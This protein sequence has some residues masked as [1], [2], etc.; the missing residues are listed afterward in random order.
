MR[1]KIYYFRNI[2][3]PL[4]LISLLLLFTMPLVVTPVDAG[5]NK[6]SNNTANT[7]YRLVFVL[8]TAENL[9]AL[10][11][12]AMDATLNAT[13]KVVLYNASEAR[14][15]DFSNASFVFLASLDNAT[16]E[17]V[18]Q[19]LNASAYVFAYNL[20]PDIS[21]GNV[22]D[23]NI[24][25]Y[26]VYGGDE[27]IRD[28]ILYICSRFYG[29]KTDFES[30]KPPAGRPKV[31]F[32]VSEKSS[33]AAW[34]KKAAD[35][36]YIS[37]CLNVSIFT[38]SVDDPSSYSGMDLSDQD[39]I[40]LWMIGFPVQDAIHE[41]VLNARARGA[42]VI[43][44]SFTDVYNM[45][46]VNLSSPEFADISAYWSNGGTE[47]MRRVLLFMGVKLCDVP[48][49]AFGLEKVPPPVEIP[50][51]GI[52]HPEAKKAGVGIDGLGIFAS[53]D[54]YLA[55]YK[56]SG[57]YNASAPTV[58]IHYYYSSGKYGSYMTL[59]PLIRMIENKG[60]N[61][62]FAS[63]S[64]KDANTTEYLLKDNESLVDS[65]IIINSFRLWYHSENAGI[66]YL[67]QINVTPLKGIISYYM[68]ETVW[69]ESN[70]LS[71]SEL[72]W[73]IALPELD[74]E[75]EFILF[76]G[77][78]KD[79]VS[80]E[81]Y[82]KPFTSQLEW[83][84]DRAISWAK[85]HDKANSDKKVAII[86]Y[87][88][89]GG[90]DNI[91]ASY[92]DMAP[93][94]AN[95]LDNMSAEGYD[96]GNRA[97]P[98][99][100]E[101]IQLMLRQGRNIGTWAPGELTSMVEN[102]TVI[103]IP[104]GK[105]EKWF[106]ELPAA[107]RQEVID[108]WGNPPGKIMVYE[109]ASG[110]YIVIPGLKFG[111]VFLAPQPTRGYLQ[112][113]KVL[114]HDRELPPH[115]Q[116]IAF[117]LWLRKEFGADA[118][119]HF[120]TH[121]TQEWLPGKE[122]ALSVRDCWP[123][124]LIQDLPVVYPYIMDNVGEGTQA[125]RR[126]N[127][128]IVDHL[129]PALVPSGLYGD[130]WNLSEAE[131]GYESA[132]DQLLK[133][134]YWNS[135][136]NYVMDI[137]LDREFNLNMDQLRTNRT[138]FEAFLKNVLDPYL[139][140]LEN[141]IIPYGLHILGES[142]ADEELVEMLAVMLGDEFMEHVKAVSPTDYKNKSMELLNA[143]ILGGINVTDAENQILGPGNG[144]ANITA[145]LNTAIKYANDIR[146]CNIEIPR[147]LAGLSGRYV[148]PKVG[149]DPI[150]HPDALPT[151]NNFYSFDPRMIPTEEAWTVGRA[152]GD[153]LLRQYKEEHN[154]TYPHR[155][156]FVL[157]AVETM[158]HWGVME[159]EI[160]YLMGVKPKWDS[161]GR[162][163][164]V[165]L[166]STSDF[167]LDGEVRPRIDILVTASG[168]YRD[169]FPDKIKLID[170]AVRLAYT[171]N[172]T[173]TQNYI[174]I[175]SDAIYT[176]LRATGDYTDTEARRLSQARIF[177]E[178]PGNYG[179]GLPDVIAASNTW[180]NEQ[181]L[182]ELYINR[183]GFVYGKDEWGQQNTAL[184]RQ[185]LETVD[186]AVHSETSNI[187]GVMD[188]DD[189]FQYLGGLALAVR[190]VRKDQNTP[191]L[192]I[193]NLRGAY[194]PETETLESFLRREF[195]AR[196]INPKWIEGMMEHG[197]S[198]AREI[199][200]EFIE[201]FWGWQVTM[202][203]MITQDMWNKVYE[204]YVRDKYNL[205]LND[206]FDKNNPFAQQAIVARMLEAIRK[207]YWKPSD[208]VKT[209]LAEIYHE[210]VEKKGVT[211]C[212]HTCGNPLLAE[213]MQGILSAS[214]SEESSTLPRAIG[215]GGGARHIETEE[216]MGGGAT[217]VTET[218]G[219]S[220]TG[221]EL[222]KP[223]ET[224]EQRGRVMKEETP[225]EKPSPV[226]PISGAPLMGI[227]IVIVFLVL[228]G[229]GLGYK[230]KRL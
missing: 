11:N 153:E 77:K 187:Y 166:L 221:E 183:V 52:Y 148:P 90:K 42:S 107:K 176:N 173:G 126:G 114:Y 165:E 175:D 192:Y 106:N 220:K 86:Y 58:G 56:G 135:T 87:N 96:V 199:D 223:P 201:N 26:W 4:I 209:T 155:V 184:F 161:K 170:E 47:N 100:T 101:L 219:V 120:G 62:I 31:A 159:S 218:T 172:D 81:Y 118:I 95:L 53:V 108:K 145:Y 130:F 60:A 10:E 103:L 117:Y 9:A 69:N 3:V 39:V 80:G 182:A 27:N 169:T 16:V 146:A 109:N 228:I 116:Y 46:S 124:I 206:F 59:D 8:G 202:P 112:D 45:S 12:A 133:N 152:M 40:F 104:A 212:H 68:N 162:V 157:W 63:F 21:I 48:I 28:M 215:G 29:T 167:A 64:Y 147:I 158:R 55:W 72:A 211:C 144:S 43:T 156:G 216:E 128:V 35:D 17:C 2:H 88:H 75:T 85:L 33:Y 127:A 143:T 20:T 185:N 89:G 151:G 30:P 136:L 113:Q 76:S 174:R 222:K 110:K 197:Y 102:G 24:T 91:G 225:V 179:T 141:E 41:T 66:D 163:K 71:P 83:I 36:V 57:R 149:G 73:Q 44:T 214:I 50:Q 25:E 168:L 22:D 150:R 14:L 99:G 105:Y 226:L 67:Q 34:L 93:S 193:T 98:G 123:A 65:L 139:E 138:A 198:G 189:Y 121:G 6:S 125:K 38:Y 207:D 18:N 32:V 19:T 181:K 23:E 115:H 142:P 134:E 74:G 49:E 129:T 177:S 213:Y 94:I 7:A 78:E 203:D 180:T 92:L 5:F 186:A 224:T 79:P 230:R 13:V 84:T 200:H 178:A 208:D 97:P 194:H 1:C 190:N 82:Y 195:Y 15:H 196:Y 227:V 140:D 122:T 54:D 61:V 205:G 164:G 210:S 188:N 204:V 191:D 229:I 37:R 154:G 51:F 132:T 137:G 160:L 171:A 70:G 111:K 131:M 217:N 119:V